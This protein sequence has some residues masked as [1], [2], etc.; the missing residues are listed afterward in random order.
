MGFVTVTPEPGLRA[1]G[2]A[3]Q[4]KGFWLAGDLVRW[5]SDMMG[6]IGG[7]V[8]RTTSAMTGKVRAGIAWSDAA[9]LHWHAWGSE[10]KLYALSQTSVTPSDITP[11]GFLA[12]HADASAGGGYGVGPYGAG[13]YGTP[14]ADTSTTQEA[15]MWTLDVWSSAGDLLASMAGDGKIYRW[16]RDVLVKAAALGGSAPTSNQGIVVTPEGFLFALGAGSDARKVQWPDQGSLSDWSPTALNQAGDNEL[17]TQG[18]IKRG[19]TLRAQ[20]LIFT[21]DDVHA[22]TYIGLPNV[23]RIERVG[24]K[25]GIIS[26]G[27]VATTGS[28]AYWM[29]PNGF[30][31]YDG[32]VRPIECAIWDS[33]FSNL[34]ATQR[35]KIT[36][37]HLTQFNE[38]WFRWPSAASTEI[39]Q[40]AA[41][42]YITGIW[43]LHPSVARL[44]GIDKGVFANPIMAS[45]DGYLYDHETGYAYGGAVPYAITGPMEIGEGERLAKVLELI[46]DEKTRGDVTVTFYGKDSPNGAETTFGPYTMADFVDM[47]F[48]TRQAKMKVSGAV[49][50]NWRWGDARLNVIP[51]ARR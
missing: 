41:Y 25:C 23:Y 30:F 49:T 43:M 16:Q 36:A 6:P 10:Q 17:Q 20:T 24:E 47:H 1:L 40:T 11:V 50:T 29:S 45:S 22:A 42:N 7:W 13:T 9:L 39:D 21:D 51:G 28:F 46:P 5:W 15:S 26:R 32:V 38:I 31:V 3:Y 8:A 44:V 18:A 19:I 4:S 37:Q 12:G 48:E 2:T 14:R 27:A 35:S 33:V 34:N